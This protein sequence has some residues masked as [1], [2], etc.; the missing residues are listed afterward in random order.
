MVSVILIWIYLIITILLMG[1]AIVEIS[2]RTL[3]YN[4]V[5]IMPYFLAGILGVTWYSQVFSLFG[6]VGLAANI[7]L[8]VICL[9]ALL[10]CSN[11]VNAVIKMCFSCMCGHKG[12]VLCAVFLFFLMAYGTS[13]G[14]I[15][16]DTGLYHAQS[17]RW[18]EEYGILRGLGNIHTRLAYNSAAFPFTALYSFSFLNKGSFHVTAGFCAL[19]LAWEC[20]GLIKN[21]KARCLTVSA[22]ARFM[23]I[24]YLLMIFDE[25]ISPASDYYMVCLAFILVIR[26]IDK[27]E[28]ENEDTASYAMLAIFAGFILTIKLSGA[29]LVL[30]AL[31]PLVEYIRKKEYLHIWECVIAGIT[32]I[33]P[34]LIRNIILSGWLLYPSTALGIFNVDWRIPEAIAVSD[35][36]EIQVYGRGFTDISKYDDGIRV[37][38]GGWFSS[39][40]VIDRLFIIAAIV[41]VIYFVVKWL[42]YGFIVFKGKRKTFPSELFYE[43]ILC[44]CFVFWLMTSPLMRYGCLYV[45]LTAGVIW[46]RC[47]LDIVNSK[48]AL[49]IIYVAL[50]LFGLYKVF[51][52]GKE[53][54]TSFRT[55]T[56]II[57]QDYDIFETKTY[58]MDGITFYA[59]TEGDRVG[60]DAFPSTPWE[61]DAELRGQDIYSGFKS[62]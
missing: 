20:M 22:F 46:S 25:M 62:K 40:S 16:Y 51:M 38:F 4:S 1:I 30:F 7:I 26:W 44:I 21:I 35:Y 8:I 48:T 60:Y 5:G 29:L 2:N 59:P 34:Y 24:Y 14:L 42:Y 43:G 11:R 3:K 31:K 55:D 9:F 57:Q 17:I 12:A 10:I 13:H 58:D 32:V 39:Q 15:H 37:W 56:F 28:A 50:A 54:I 36:K 45:Y 61:V 27:C 33:V 18:I 52:F 23:S 49:R 19:L 53:V 47:L 41:G 6:K